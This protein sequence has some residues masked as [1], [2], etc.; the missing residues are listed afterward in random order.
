MTISIF[1]LKSMTYSNCHTNT[2]HACCTPYCYIIA[3]HT[4]SIEPQIKQCFRYLIWY[5]RG[6]KGPCWEKPAS[7]AA[8]GHTGLGPPI[9]VP[10]GT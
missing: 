9:L 5:P 8:H 10:M 4:C 3:T 6:S 2:F 7:I 1:G